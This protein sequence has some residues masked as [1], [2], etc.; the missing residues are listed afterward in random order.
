MFYFKGEKGPQ[1]DPGYIIIHHEK[2]QKGDPGPPGEQGFP[3]ER[4]NKKIGVHACRCIKMPD[5]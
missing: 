5:F 1:G 2:G 3:G 4:G